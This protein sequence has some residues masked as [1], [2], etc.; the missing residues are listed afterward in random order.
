M[1]MSPS[2]LAPFILLPIATKLVHLCR[3]QPIILVD[4][5]I[6][7]LLA[8]NQVAMVDL[9]STFVSSSTSPLSS[10]STE[11]LLSGA[12]VSGSISQLLS[13][14]KSRKKTMTRDERIADLETE[15]SY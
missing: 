7:M 4:H 12:S 1:M 15:I 13:S 14:K 10:N 6:G 3:Q 11:L 8:N 9:E 2:L 5:P